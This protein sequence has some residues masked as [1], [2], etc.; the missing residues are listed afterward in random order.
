M[1]AVFTVLAW[2]TLAAVYLEAC[3]S[4]ADRLHVRRVRRA[5]VLDLRDSKKVR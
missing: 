2:A 3:M 4:L 1:T 5:G